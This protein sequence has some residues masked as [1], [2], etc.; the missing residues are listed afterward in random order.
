MEGIALIGV[1][2]AVSMLM[3]W[4]FVHDKAPDGKTRGLFAMMEPGMRR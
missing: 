2:V 4:L 1:F 3:R